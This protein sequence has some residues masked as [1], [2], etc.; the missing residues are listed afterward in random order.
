MKQSTST[1]VFM[2]LLLF[3][4]VGCSA[5]NETAALDDF[6]NNPSLKQVHYG[7]KG[8]E[9]SS[10]RY[11]VSRN[12]EGYKYQATVDDEKSASGVCKY[13]SK[14]PGD[15]GVDYTLYDCQG[16]DEVFTVAFIPRNR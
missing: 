4:L 12:E 9:G 13:F 8:F 1:F 14:T 11:H 3:S 15:A 6:L 16:T 7:F 10:Y 2:G 5:A